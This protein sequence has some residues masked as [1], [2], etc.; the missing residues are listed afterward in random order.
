MVIPI[1]T[2]THDR[3]YYTTFI[4]FFIQ[5]ICNDWTENADHDQMAQMCWHILVCID[6]TGTS[7]CSQ[8]GYIQLWP[9]DILEFKEN[10]LN[11]LQCM[12][13]LKSHTDSL[14]QMCICHQLCILHTAYVNNQNFWYCI[15]FVI[16]YQLTWIQEQG[17]HIYLWYVLVYST[18]VVTNE[19]N[20]KLPS[21]RDTPVMLILALLSI[22]SYPDEFL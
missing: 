14:M 6:C 15:V 1:Q 3:Y 13:S 20:Q 21:T 17:R 8:H 2:A 4:E 10:A 12:S 19:W 11:P 9:L 16:L 18:D 22:Y 7:S 5:N